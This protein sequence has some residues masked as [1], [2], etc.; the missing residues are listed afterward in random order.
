MGTIIQFP[1]RATKHAT[2]GD[3]LPS[4]DADLWTVVENVEAI[5]SHWNAAIQNLQILLLMVQGN[6]TKEED[7]LGQIE[8]IHG[9]LLS[10][11]SKLNN[12]NRLFQQSASASI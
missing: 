4:P 1:A 6:P 9:Q 3:K 12:A 11:S 5:R 8:E 10:V 7:L 2:D